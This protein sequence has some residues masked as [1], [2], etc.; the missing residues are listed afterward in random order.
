MG[1]EAHLLYT[2]PLSVLHNPGWLYCGAKSQIVPQ[3][4]LATIRSTAFCHVR[5]RRG[6][7]PNH[8]VR[9][10]W[11]FRLPIRDGINQPTPHVEPTTVVLAAKR[12]V[13][14][15]AKPLP[16]RCRYRQVARTRE[17]QRQKDDDHRTSC[18]WT[19]WESNPGP[20][21]DEKACEAN[22]LPTELHALREEKR[23][24]ASAEA[25]MDELGIEP[26]TFRIH[27]VQGMLSERSTN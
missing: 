22:A 5:A 9:P 23:G 18:L 10:T 2:V 6:R 15:G 11:C 3:L 7:S 8:S 21:A 24:S 13:T 26:R 19:S 16:N 14:S 12:F 1:F 4:A 25:V 20:F 27:F 17:I